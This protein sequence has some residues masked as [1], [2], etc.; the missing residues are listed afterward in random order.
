MANASACIFFI[1]PHMTHNQEE[2]KPPNWSLDCENVR[3]TR[4]A[5]ESEFATE[6]AIILPLFCHYFAT[7]LFPDKMRGLGTR[8]MR[9]PCSARPAHISCK[10]L[11][12]IDA[13]EA[14]NRSSTTTQRNFHGRP[15]CHRTLPVDPRTHCRERVTTQSYI[16][17][18]NQP[19]YKNRFLNETPT[20]DGQ[21]F[22]RFD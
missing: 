14:F 22:A 9:S 7:M 8:C 5:K 16:N 6:Y 4:G 17:L 10:D 21:I 12:Q 13:K 3:N 1:N 2:D 11:V 20:V 15:R 19:D 18:D